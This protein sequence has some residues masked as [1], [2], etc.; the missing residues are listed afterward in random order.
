M[1]HVTALY[2]EWR[3]PYITHT[4][5]WVNTRCPFCGD[6]GAHLGCAPNSLVYNCWRC[7]RHP[8]VD[9]IS[10]LLGVPKTEARRIVAAHRKTTPAVTNV[11]INRRVVIQPTRLPAPNGPLTPA[12]RRYLKRRGFDPDRLAADW[13]LLSA[14]PI[15]LFENIN[16]AH[17]ILIPVYW[18]GE[19]ATF[20]ARATGG[21]DDVK[22]LAC[23]QSRETQPIKNILYIDE[24]W[25]ATHDQC[26]IVEGVTD[27]WRLGPYAG[28]TFGVDFKLE[29]VMAVPRHMKRICVLYD[30]E[31]LAQQR[32]EQLVI[33]LRMLGKQA[34]THT[35]P[36]GDP[37]DLSQSEADYLVKQ[38]IT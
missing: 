12:H 24:Q 26:I 17:R 30:S 32:A 19:L 10:A 27:V 9:T 15:A 14:G 28:A 21:N 18:G 1:S 23:P 38:I 36:T 35:L 4:N 37:G 34:F 20:Q 3:I 13:G 25:W 33:K 6:R 16:Y 2:D 11:A 7:G 22:Y 29:Q 31:P 8:A 5:G